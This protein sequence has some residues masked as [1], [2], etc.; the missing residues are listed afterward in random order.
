MNPNL[1][2]PVV[3]DTLACRTKAETGPASGCTN[4]APGTCVGTTRP[5]AKG[6]NFLIV[7]AARGWVVTSLLDDTGCPQNVVA[8][9]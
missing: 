2:I 7:F 3:L 8:S 6:G 5:A 1:L 9:C 4:I